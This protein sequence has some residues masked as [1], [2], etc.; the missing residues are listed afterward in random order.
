MFANGSYTV[1]QNPTIGS[2]TYTI[3]IVPEPGTALLVGA[4][5]VGLIGAARRARR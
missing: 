5:L 2:G 1:V 3:S 4:G